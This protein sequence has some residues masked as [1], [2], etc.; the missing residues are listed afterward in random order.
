MT[1]LRFRQPMNAALVVAVG[2]GVAS[3][4]YAQSVPVAQPR[5]VQARVK[6]SVA[7][8]SSAT[9]TI[10]APA[11]AAPTDQAGENAIARAGTINVSLESIRAYVAALNPRDRAAVTKD[12][13]LLDQAVRQMLAN[14]LLL[15]E[16]RARKWDQ[17][18]NVAA[19]LDRVRESALAELYL[20]SVSAPPQDFPSDEDI[21]KVYDA[22]RDALLMPRQFELAQIFIAAPKGVDGGADDKVKKNV[23]DIVRKAKAPGA[24]FTAVATDAGTPNGG[25]LGWLLESQI[26]PGIRDRIEG[27]AKGA[28]SDPI[29]LDDGWHIVKLIDTKAAYTR[30]LPEVRDQLVLQIRKERMQM[31]E[32]AYLV[33]L[34]KKNPPAINEL[35]LSKIMDDP[36]RASR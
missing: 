18:P 4:A 5:Q 9:A 30:T 3:Q 29:R 20:Q 22:N 27:L 25:N 31:L 24:D 33:E 35:A 2:L 16:A 14:Q 7:A 12:P 13:T 15:H 34:L 10:A 8:A 36:T 19:E 21:Q 11:Q 23:D 6:P 1:G 17:Q 28:V 32:R 26:V